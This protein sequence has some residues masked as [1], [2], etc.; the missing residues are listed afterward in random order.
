MLHGVNNMSPVWCLTRT[1]RMEYGIDDACESLHFDLSTPQIKA[2][3]TFGW[4]VHVTGRW[5]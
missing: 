4:I 2:G 1:M 5:G 3:G